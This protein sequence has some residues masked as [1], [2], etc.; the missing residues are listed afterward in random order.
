MNLTTGERTRLF[1]RAVS[2]TGSSEWHDVDRI[3]ESAL[4]VADI[5]RD[6]VFMVDPETEEGLRQ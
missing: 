4:L 3:N 6:R 1:S 2:T 5:K